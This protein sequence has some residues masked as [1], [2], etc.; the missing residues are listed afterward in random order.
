MSFKSFMDDVAE[1]ERNNRKFRK[2]ADGDPEIR[3]KYIGFGLN[4]IVTCSIMIAVS[5]AGIIANI[6]LSSFDTIGAV[7]GIF[8]GL[9]SALIGLAFVISIYKIIPHIVWQRR[10]NGRKIWIVATVLVV[11]HIVFALALIGTGIMIFSAGISSC[12]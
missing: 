9:F 10:L 3:E 7:G 2:I 11:L 4:A 6:L 1:Y 5:V 8:L 12:S